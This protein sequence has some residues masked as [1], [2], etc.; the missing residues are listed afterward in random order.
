MAKHASLP[1]WSL[2]SPYRLSKHFTSQ[3]PVKV[4][5]VPFVSGTVSDVSV[6]RCR[7][8]SWA[9]SANLH[10]FLKSRLPN[11]RPKVI[12]I[13]CFQQFDKM[14]KRQREIDDAR[15]EDDARGYRWILQMLPLK[16]HQELHVDGGNVNSGFLGPR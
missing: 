15:E 11:P 6:R 2:H 16:I 14:S 1:F 3:N 10:H 9:F 8:I 12:H 13:P 4:K 7:V 5:C